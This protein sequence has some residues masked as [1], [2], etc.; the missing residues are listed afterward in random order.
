MTEALAERLLDLHCRLL[1]LYI[2]Q[3]ADCLHWENQQPFFESERGS[4][5]IQM[6][7]LYMKGTRQDLWNSVPPSM[8]QRVFAGMLNETL[9]ILTVRYTQTI[10]SKARSQLLLVDVANI[11]LC[12]AEL[13][14]S[15]CEHGEAYI[16]LNITNQSKIIRDVHA[17]CHELFCCLLLRGAPIGTLYKLVKKGTESVGIFTARKGYPSPW[18]IF[19]LPKMFPPNLNGHWATKVSEFGI[20]AALTIELK[21]LLASPQANWPLLI[22]VLLMRDA[23]L[24]SIIF[25][26]LMKY[27]PACDEFVD[28][29]I[30]PCMNQ[31][32][33]R[34]KCEGFLCGKECKDIAEWA[35]DQ[36]QPHQQTNY[37]T[38][39]ALS[40]IVIMTGKASD[41]NRTLISALDKSQIK[42]WADC[43]DRRQVWNQKRPPW[44]E[45][46]IHLV[47]PVLDPI[48]HMLINAMQTGASNYQAMA[49]AITC[50]AE[51]W[52]AI[53][54]CLYTVIMCLIEILPADIKPLADSVLIQILFCALYT[55][56]ME[57]AQGNEKEDSEKE[58]PVVVNENDPTTTVVRSRKTVCQVLAECVCAIDEENKHTELLAAL[59][60]QAAESQRRLRIETEIDDTGISNASTSK[61]D[62]I[63][64]LLKP[65]AMACTDEEYDVENADYISEVLAS[66][67]LTTSVGKQSVKM[68][69][70]YIK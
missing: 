10:P 12:V 44:L 31:E 7:W 39:L 63:D 36:K 15:I 19:T 16:G 67:V 54:D 41:I 21:V 35:A 52:D 47:Y 65:I 11:L 58:L 4:Y 13:L 49:L 66:D 6:W 70:K 24:S 68:M 17:K 64:S 20:F 22:K 23:H 59:V 62:E 48:A 28:S 53:P 69:Y 37:Q 1:T 29:S 18:I 40:Y 30:Q 50:L 33:L 32:G 46:I 34:T 45:A 2:I 25:H 51:M 8:A 5:T 42:N 56:L 55:K 9:T 43:L 61:L 38:I 3:D 57:C 26:H 27:L 60:H 14:P